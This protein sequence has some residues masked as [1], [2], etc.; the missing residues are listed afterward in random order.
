MGEKSSQEK[1]ARYEQPSKKA[2]TMEGRIPLRMLL[3]A[4]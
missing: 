3:K 2:Q 4:C 1:G